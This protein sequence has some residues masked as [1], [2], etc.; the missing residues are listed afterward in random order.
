M[1]GN[2]NCALLNVLFL[3]CMS[4]AEY[5]QIEDD[6]L[7]HTYLYICVCLNREIYQ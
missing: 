3:L 7:I 4:F 2:T 6:L 1:F 5:M